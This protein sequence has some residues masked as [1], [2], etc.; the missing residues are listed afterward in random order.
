MPFSVRAGEPLSFWERIAVRVQARGDAH[1]IHA[2]Q[3]TVTSIGWL[4]RGYA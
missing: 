1:F 2:L 3:P 4:Q